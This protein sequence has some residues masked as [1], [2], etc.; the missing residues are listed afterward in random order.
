MRERVVAVVL[1]VVAVLAFSAGVGF[2]GNILQSNT[3][4]ITTTKTT[5]IANTCV[6]PAGSDV[7]L[8]VVNSSTKQP[9]PSVPVHVKWHTGLCAP[10]SLSAD[11]GTY[12]TN[13]SGY[14]RLREPVGGYDMNVTYGGN[15]FV[16]ASSQAPPRTISKV[17]L[18]I[19]SGSVTI[20][21]C[22]PSC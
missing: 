20:L 4:T 10:E 3:T 13:S 14:I 18:E 5:Q 9:I 15:Y 8:Y 2:D 17:M 21:Y 12:L 11:L 1:V 19:P 6:V 16:Q 22:N 7:F